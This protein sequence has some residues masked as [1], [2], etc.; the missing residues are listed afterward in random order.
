VSTGENGLF[1]TY[2][3]KIDDAP[4]DIDWFEGLWLSTL[5]V[6]VV[7]TFTMFDW[8]TSR[9]GR[10]G[11]ALLTAVRFGGTFLVMLLCSRRKSNFW[12]WVIAIP[13]SLTILAYDFIRLPL[14][15]ERDPVLWFILLRQGLMFAA[16]FMLFTPR[17]RAW[18]ADRPP[19]GDTEAL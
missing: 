18:F 10:N 12:L 15:L 8:S 5:V 3:Q 17:S 2:F 4:P 14:I 16:I 6:S 7:I 9:L 1:G 19:P 13:F 11:A